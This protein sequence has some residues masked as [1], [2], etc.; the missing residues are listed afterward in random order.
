MLCEFVCHEATWSGTSV[1][2]DDNVT[3]IINNGNHDGDSNN[4]D[5]DDDDDDDDFVL[6]QTK[7][8]SKIP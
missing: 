8:H 7:L 3:M 5:D 1:D 6:S 2:S 4:D